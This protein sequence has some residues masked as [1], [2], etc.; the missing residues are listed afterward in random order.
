MANKNRFDVSV[1][2]FK[3]GRKRPEQSP[4][5]M[6]K[7]VREN[8]ESVQASSD[9]RALERR[10]NASDAKELRRAKEEGRIFSKIPIEDVATSNLPRDRIDLEAIAHS[11]EMA[12]L[13]AS[14]KGR[15]QREP[16]EVYLDEEGGYQLK[17]GWRRLEALR[18]LKRSD[19]GDRFSFVLAKV[20]DDTEDRISL[21][22]DMVEENLIRDDL[23]FSEMARLAI[24]V[25]EDPIV[26]ETEPRAVVGLLYDS[27]N[28]TKRS[29]IRSFVD[30]LVTLEASLQWPKSVGRNVGVEIAR[31]MVSRPETV[32]SLK[33]ALS[34]CRM[35]KDQD[36][37][38]KRYL[39]SNGE[40]DASNENKEGRFV[41][42]KLRDI[43][44]K[45]R[46][47][48]CRLLWEQDFGKVDE[49]KLELSLIHI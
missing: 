47:R 7:A 48:E 6:K 20:C 34:S 40:L 36:K 31:M 46:G 37:V 44:L 25:A 42:I 4:G 9:A 32:P 13:K 26:A 19:G 15:G 39:A 21:F 27:V 16:I 45:A 11:D 23:S 33:K 24:T 22:R 18:Q 2:D 17:I 35:E 10:Q 28:K 3:P 38:L 8:A 41:R 12:E 29:Y 43:S 1:V 49:E 5:P 14:I 30:L